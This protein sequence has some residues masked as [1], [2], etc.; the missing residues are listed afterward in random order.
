VTLASQWMIAPEKALQTVNMTMQWGVRTCIN[1]TLSRWFLTN[2]QLIRLTRFAH[3]IHGHSGCETRSNRGNKY[4]KVFAVPF[5]WT[6]AFLMRRKG[7]AHEALSFLFHL[8]GVLPAMV[9]G[10]LK[11]QML[12]DFRRK[13]KE[14]DCHLRQ[15]EPYSPWMNVAVS[16]IWEL[17]KGVSRMMIWTRSPKILWDHCIELE[18]LIRLHSDNSTYKTN[19]QVP[20]TIMMGTTSDISH[21]GEFGWYDWV[22]FQDNTPTFSKNNIVLSRYLGPATNVGGMMTAKILKENGQFI[23]ITEIFKYVLWVP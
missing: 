11:E 1:P 21:I 10:S 9:M 15:T 19:R 17:K 5:G 12:G 16:A 4:S 3:H 2:D 20:E 23:Y 22:M 14:A 6:R 8:D 7:E 13:L 18:A